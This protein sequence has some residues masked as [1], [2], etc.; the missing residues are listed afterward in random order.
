MQKESC[1]AA[2]LRQPA[3]DLHR[4]H[5]GPTQV[6]HRCYTGVGPEEEGRHI[7]KCRWRFRSRFAF[8]EGCVVSGVKRGKMGGGDNVSGNGI[9]HPA[10]LLPPLI[11]YGGARHSAAADRRRRNLHLFTLHLR[12]PFVTVRQCFI[13]RC[14]ILV[15]DA[16]PKE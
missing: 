3:P 7:G 9:I 1:R 13:D 14:A 6:L 4:T 5:T 2:A 10:A 8:A 12:T 15:E 16:S 11:S